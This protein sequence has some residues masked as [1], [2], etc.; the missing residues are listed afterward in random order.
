MAEFWWAMLWATLV[1]PLMFLWGFTLVDLF[2]RKDIGWSKAPWALL[3][4]FLPVIGVIVY[5]IARPK[6]YD[7]WEPSE[8]QADLY[9]TPSKY[10]AESSYRDSQTSGAVR[11]VEALMRMHETGAISDEEFARMKDRVLAT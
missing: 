11:D 1:I 9:G 10:Y 4:L 2:R 5:F 7:S 8:A 3:I 6:D